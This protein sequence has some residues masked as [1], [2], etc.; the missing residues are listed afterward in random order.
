MEPSDL[1]TH[2][3][4]PRCTVVGGTLS[5]S[6]CPHT[7]PP[8]QTETHQ[9]GCPPVKEAP[10][11]PRRNDLHFYVSHCQMSCKDLVLVLAKLHVRISLARRFRVKQTAVSLRRVHVCH[12]THPHHL[13]PQTSGSLKS[14]YRESAPSLPFYQ[15]KKKHLLQGEE[16]AGVS[17]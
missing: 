11:T 9:V 1:S 6:V 4:T 5:G 10:P 14:Q 13:T 2:S 16:F 15:K 17:N 8:P 3:V 12:P 7:P